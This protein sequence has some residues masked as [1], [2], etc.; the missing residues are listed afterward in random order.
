M[1]IGGPFDGTKGVFGA[2]APRWDPPWGSPARQPRDAS[3]PG[4]VFG[5]LNGLLIAAREQLQAFAEGRTRYFHYTELLRT[6]VQ[7]CLLDAGESVREELEGISTIDFSPSSA[8]QAY[9]DRKVFNDFEAPGDPEFPRL[10]KE[11]DAQTPPKLLRMIELI[12]QARGKAL[13]PNVPAAPPPQGTSEVK[14]SGA[15]APRGSYSKGDRALYEMIGPDDLARFT[16]SE[17]WRRRAR[18][19]QK[20]KPPGKEITPNAFRARLFRIRKHHGVPAP[21]L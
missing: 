11:Y 8:L 5:R 20:V 9:Y 6:Q 19:A 1:P 16:D 3:S 15:E 4:M 7:Q 17:L 2:Y 21:K 14:G 12:T 10:Q 13:R 18:Y